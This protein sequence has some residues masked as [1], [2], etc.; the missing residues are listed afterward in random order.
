VPFLHFQE[1]RVRIVIASIALFFLAIL[2]LR[3]RAAWLAAPPRD[4]R[5]AARE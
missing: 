2:V 5:M 3:T 1:V 4:G